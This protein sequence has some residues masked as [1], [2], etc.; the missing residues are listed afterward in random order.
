[1][2]RKRERERVK[3]RERKR[4]NFGENAFKSISSHSSILLRRYSLNNFQPIINLRRGERERDK[5]QQQKSS[6]STKQCPFA[7]YLFCVLESTQLFRRPWKNSKLSS[8]LLWGWGNE[9]FFP[10]LI[11]RPTPGLNLTAKRSLFPFSTKKPFHD[12]L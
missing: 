6:C 10:R 8:S 2:G 7:R 5:L 11:S 3:E 1:M 4:I 12:D 9:A